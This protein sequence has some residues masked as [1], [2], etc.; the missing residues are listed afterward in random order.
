VIHYIVL[1]DQQ[2]LVCETKC[3]VAFMEPLT[4]ERPV[5]GPARRRVQH[6]Q[7]DI[8]RHCRLRH[9]NRPQVADVFDL[10][11]VAA[12]T[13]E[14]HRMD[15]VHTDAAAAAP[16]GGH[17]SPTPASGRAAAPL[18]APRALLLRLIDETL[19]RSPWPPR[20]RPCHRI[21]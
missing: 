20:A 15:L 18:R 13:S 1:S 6:Y 11:L 5:P 4:T 8:Y 2:A 7:A 9:P 12:R 3:V 17:A 16:A 14:A 10:L 19:E 21:S